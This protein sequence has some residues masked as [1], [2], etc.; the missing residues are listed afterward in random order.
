MALGL[1][2]LPRA[3]LRGDDDGCTTSPTCQNKTYFLVYKTG[4][5]VYQKAHCEKGE[6][7]RCRN[8]VAPPPPYLCNES[9]PK[10][11]IKMYIYGANACNALCC[12]NA[13]T[14]SE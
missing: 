14:T 12:L 4:C 9:N 11:T 7:G 6:R 3:V 10:E 2:L 5:Y 8:I 1:F 13:T